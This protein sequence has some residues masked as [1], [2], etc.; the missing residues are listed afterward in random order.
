MDNEKWEEESSKAE[1]NLEKRP[2]G[3]EKRNGDV[4]ELESK[5]DEAEVGGSGKEAGAGVENMVGTG[6]AEVGRQNEGEANVLG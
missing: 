2:R 5:P 4:D 6:D 3:R 1:A